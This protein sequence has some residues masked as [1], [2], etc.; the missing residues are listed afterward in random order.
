MS[1]IV[2]QGEKLIAR[3]IQAVSAQF[4]DMTHHER[5]GVHTALHV[6][7]VRAREGGCMFTGRRRVL[8]VVQADEIEVSR[9]ADGSSTLRSVSGSNA[10][11]LI[12]QRFEAVGPDSTRVRTTVELPLR[13]MLRL[14]SPLL[15]MGLQRD[16]DK[17]LEEDRY[18]LETRGY[19]AG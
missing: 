11:L 1:S 3:P 19:P 7:N 8:G 12:T 14:L 9:R 4:T 13:G 15:R 6:S 17:A 2:V 5:A 10:G 18:D 16:V